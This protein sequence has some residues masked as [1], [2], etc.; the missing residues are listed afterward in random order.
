MKRPARPGTKPKVEYSQR[1]L[2][3][4]IFKVKTTPPPKYGERLFCEIVNATK[5]YQPDTTL[6]LDFLSR[7]L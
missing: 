5:S 7:Y 3:T 1:C 4:S 6:R 2:I